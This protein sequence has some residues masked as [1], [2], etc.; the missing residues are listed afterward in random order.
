MEKCQHKPSWKMRVVEDEQFAN[1]NHYVHKCEKC[2]EL[3]E[4]GFERKDGKVYRVW[5]VYEIAG[6]A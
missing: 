1:I 2:G 5:V 3:I 4:R 6:A